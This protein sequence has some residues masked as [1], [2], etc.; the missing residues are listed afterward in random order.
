[1]AAPPYFKEDRTF[2]PQ[3]SPLKAGQRAKYAKGDSPC[4][5]CVGGA[6][7]KNCKGV[8]RDG[9][10]CTCACP[11]A[12]AFRAEM[13]AQTESD[14]TKTFAEHA[15]AHAPAIYNSSVGNSSFPAPGDRRRS[16]SGVR[17]VSEQRSATSDGK[18]SSSTS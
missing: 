2:V 3:R 8:R 10:V 1:M 16:S 15:L 9:E 6:A 18:K 7:H 11:R 12:V 4:G 17:T 14:P 13:C 5:E